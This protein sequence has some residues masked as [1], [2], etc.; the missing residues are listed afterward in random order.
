LKKQ[1]EVRELNLKTCRLK[2]DKLKNEW[3]YTS[4]PPY[5]FMAETGT[6]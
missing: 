3:R 4:T 2:G 1:P 5:S 6:V